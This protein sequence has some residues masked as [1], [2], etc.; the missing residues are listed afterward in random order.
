MKRR[1]RYLLGLAVLAI[2]VIVIV[3]NSLSSSNPGK[4]GASNSV[5]KPLNIV[6]GPAGLVS[7]TAPD[8]SNHSWVLVNLGTEAN[9]QQ[10]NVVNGKEAGVVPVTN[11]ARVVAVAPGGQ[12]GVG[13]GGT[14]SGAVELYSA[15]GF[16]LQGTV[17]VAGP[18]SDLV[19]GSDGVSYY[20]LQSVKGAE[21]VAVVDAK[22]MKLSGTIA[23]PSH[24]L[25]IA[26][27]PDMTTIY[28]LQS[29]GSI[30]LSDAQTGALT[31]KIPLTAGVRQMA[32]SQDGATLYVLKGSVKDDNVSEID[33]TTETTVRVLPA[34]QNTLWIAP[35]SDGTTLFDFV[36]TA[37]TGNI[38]SFATHR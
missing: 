9:L 3:V 17:P 15:Q 24:T 30:T 25:S 31:Q 13:L 37:K 5:T 6:A 2:I 35:S 18:V 8:P 22:T 34:P 27:S 11:Q 1:L 4:I 29:N 21:S 33:L 19:A 23:L 38:Q 10:I 7:G 32:L 36:G 20:A 14:N 28:S 16:N 12:F 26:V